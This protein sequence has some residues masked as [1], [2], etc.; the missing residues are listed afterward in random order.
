MPP[1]RQIAFALRIAATPLAVLL[2]VLTA[3]CGGA[4]E[5]H[6][7]AGVPLL[8][9]R[10]GASITSDLAPGARLAT[11]FAAAYAQGAYRQHPPALP[12]ATQVLTHQLAQAATRVPPSRRHLRP[13]VLDLTLTPRGTASLHGSVEIGD[14]HSRPFSVG[15]TLKKRDSGW[16][17]VAASPPG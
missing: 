5:G 16:R 11:R 13:R 10:Q 6:R 1:P 3:S 2:A 12:G 15:F 7:P 9:G 4:G 17:V 8:Q 14:R